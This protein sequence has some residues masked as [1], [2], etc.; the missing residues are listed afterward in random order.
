MKGRRDFQRRKLK[1]PFLNYRH[2]NKK[3]RGSIFFIV[4]TLVLF[5]TL[6]IFLGNYPAFKIKQVD[7]SGNETVSQQE[8]TLAINKQFAK[9]RF[10]F[11]R[12]DSIFFFSSKQARLALVHDY[13]F[14][15]VKVSKKLFDKV[16]IEIKEKIYSII[17]ISGVH[18]YY[19]GPNG[20]VIKEIQA[21][22][23]VTENDGNAELI[24]FGPAQE[25]FPTLYDQS[26]SEISMNGSVLNEEFVN[27]VIDL[28]T[29]L[30]EQSDFEA[31]YYLTPS[32]SS[33]QLIVATTEGWQA[34]F[35]T[36]DSVD[37]QIDKLSLILKN[38]VDN[39]LKLQYIDLRFG[40]KV[41]YK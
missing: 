12:Q 32:L 41:F 31:A 10:W 24:R 38:K 21:D 11:F 8:I 27:F 13:A 4:L 33:D 9:K 39:R 5:F 23:T 29:K 28:D 7:I 20:A 15:D 30:K 34:I 35:R 37:T 14:G 22:N 25:N 18:K 6:L 16:R 36:D 26:S 1:N 2:K 17:L 40:D 3:L 19:I